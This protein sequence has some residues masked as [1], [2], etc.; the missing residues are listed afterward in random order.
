MRPGAQALRL[1]M[2]TEFNN[3][4]RCRISPAR[5]SL[6]NYSGVSARGVA[7]PG[8]YIREQFMNQGPVFQ[9]LIRL[10]PGMHSVFKPNIYQPIGE[11]PQLLGLGFSGLYALM[12]N[13]GLGHVF[14]HRLAMLPSPAQFPSRFSMPH[15]LLSYSAIVDTFGQNCQPSSPGPNPYH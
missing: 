15:G 4:H 2:L 14:K 5:F 8:R 9:N 3:G 6:F 1:T 13:Q 12:L 7:E 11:F 10:S